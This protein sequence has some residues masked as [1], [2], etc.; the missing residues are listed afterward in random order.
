M[1][2]LITNILLT[3]LITTIFGCSPEKGYTSYKSVSN[4]GLG[5]N[6]IIFKI[7]KKIV[8]SSKKNIFL[9]LR[10]NNDYPYSNIF[11]LACLRSGDDKI[12]NDTLEYAMSSVDGSWLGTGFNE[13]KESKLWWKGGV[14]L[15]NQKPLTIEISQAV[16]NNGEEK[17]VSK[18]KGI[19]SVGI[20]IE[21]Q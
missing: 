2:R 4:D 6:P 7:P 11:L 5:V 9:R 15:S 13:I 12:Y 16:R 18:L 20:S 8:N 1:N 14:I 19:I 10:N 17:G 3:H 21:D